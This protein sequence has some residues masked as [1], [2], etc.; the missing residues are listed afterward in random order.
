MKL[1]ENGN[2][3]IVPNFDAK[4]TVDVNG[5]EIELD[6]VYI[7]G[8]GVI[9]HKFYGITADSPLGFE[10]PVWGG[11]LT[12]SSDFSLSNIDTVKFGLVGRC[13]F[14]IKYMDMDDYMVL[15]KLSKERVVTVNY[16][17]RERNERVTQEMAFTGNEMK[18]IYAMR[19]VVGMLDVSVKLV[20]T[21]RE[22]ADLIRNVFK[23]TFSPDPDKGGS[24]SIP[25]QE[26][27]YSDTCDLPDGSGFSRSGYRII[28]WATKDTKG[29]YL[30]YYNLN[31][32]ITVWEDLNLYAVWE[33]V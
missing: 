11:N 20:A 17:N 12:R 26:I 10:E 33:K 32:K 29:N 27:N 22:K 28:Y 18:K 19:G 30:R 2:T 16:Y 6:T 5:V 4:K 9:N 24:G 25:S 31:Q 14:T 7:T 15:C 3:R 23:V 8:A 13:E 1:T 21:N